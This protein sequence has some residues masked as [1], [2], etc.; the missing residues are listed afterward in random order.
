MLSLRTCA[1]ALVLFFKELQLC[2]VGTRTLHSLR[3]GWRMD[4]EDRDV[5][6]MVAATA[7][8]VKEGGVGMVHTPTV[9]YTSM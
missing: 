1:S 7:Q 4:T 5:L 6:A 8:A 3:L 9:R 2:C